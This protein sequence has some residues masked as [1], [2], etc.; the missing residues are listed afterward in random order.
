DSSTG[1]ASSGDLTVDGAHDPTLDFGF[2]PNVVPQPPT[3]GGELPPTGGDVAN[4]LRTTA[5]FVVLGAVLVMLSR[6]RR[7][8]VA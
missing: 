6:R 7:R 3:P 2:V 5:L 4:T 8:R 1:S